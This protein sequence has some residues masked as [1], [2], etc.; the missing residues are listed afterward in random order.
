MKINGNL[1]SK[2]LLAV[3]SGS[4]LTLLIVSSVFFLP[5]VLEFLNPSQ[6]NDP[7]G[8]PVTQMT[9]GARIAEYMD[10][11]SSDILFGS[12]FNNSFV[13][14]NLSDIVH[15]YVDGFII[16]G[17]PMN[18]S[19]IN[20]TIVHVLGANSTI[21]NT[22][23]FISVTDNF[24]IAMRGLDNV[25]AEVEN[26]NDIMP[27]TFMWDI[28]FDDNTS[29]S[30]V[31]SQERKVMAAVNGTWEM[32]SFGFGD[33][34]PIFIDFPNFEYDWEEY[35]NRKYLVLDEESDA[36]IQAAILNFYNMIKEAL[37]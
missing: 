20:L 23:E 21:I 19:T 22:N 13:N 30:L 34:P 16:Y 32:S 14:T 2:S 24:E 5:L 28:A 27:T 3:V 10:T 12:S 33:D 29:L 37:E 36:L 9:I 8:P 26:W 17:A 31:Y 7:N 25:S 15:D 11:R 1:K 35:D 6:L 4:L 18:G